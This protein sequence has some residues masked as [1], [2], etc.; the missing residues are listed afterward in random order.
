VNGEF[1]EH[2]KK[3]TALLNDRDEKTPPHR[4]SMDYKYNIKTN[5]IDREKE[6]V[7]RRF[8]LLP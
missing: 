7:R 4:L 1:R 6:V 3:V 2:H 5:E 8:A